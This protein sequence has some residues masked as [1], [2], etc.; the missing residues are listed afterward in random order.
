MQNVETTG[1]IYK[2]V[3]LNPLQSIPSMFRTESLGEILTPLYSMAKVLLTSGFNL[4]F[5]NPAN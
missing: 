2:P 5:E 3:L 1:L 4:S